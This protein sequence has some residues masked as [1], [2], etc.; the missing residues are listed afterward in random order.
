MHTE[1][2][3]HSS[4]EHCRVVYL[5][6]VFHRPKFIQVMINLCG[7]I[8]TAVKAKILIIRTGISTIARSQPGFE[9]SIVSLIY[10]HNSAYHT[11][12]VGL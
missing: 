12:I 6:M 10:V 9:L 4:H 8:G 2:W 1:Q 7:I 11:N 5:D 3:T